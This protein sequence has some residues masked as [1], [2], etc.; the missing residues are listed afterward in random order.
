MNT[1]FKSG[2]DISF[3]LGE[4][5]KARRVAANLTQRQLSEKSGISLST[6]RNFEQTGKITLSNLIELLRGLN[7][8]HQLDSLMPLSGVKAED[9]LNVEK[10]KKILRRRRV[11]HK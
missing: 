3:E 2:P 7:V 11:R 9:I 6:I 1:L 5:L 10:T 8:L 4:R